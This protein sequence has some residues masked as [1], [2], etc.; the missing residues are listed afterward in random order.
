M[1]RD[2]FLSGKRGLPKTLLNIFHGEK[3]QKRLW[4][5]IL[6]GQLPQDFFQTVGSVLKPLRKLLEAE[7]RLRHALKRRVPAGNRLLGGVGR[8]VALVKDVLH[9]DLVDLL[10]LPGQEIPL[11]AAVVFCDCVVQLPPVSRGRFRRK[12]KS[13]A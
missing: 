4:K 12:T 13:C 6:L 8:R 7:G 9:Q 1:G 5:E 2:F 3:V 11:E 10:V